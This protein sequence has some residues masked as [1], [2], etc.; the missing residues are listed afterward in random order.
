MY[1]LNIQKMKKNSR[2]IFPANKN[3]KNILVDEIIE[4][5]NEIHLSRKKIDEKP[6]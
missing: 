4:K 2:I 3:L 1:M 5:I 6:K